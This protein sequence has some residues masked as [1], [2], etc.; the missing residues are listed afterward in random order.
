M[1]EL[2]ASIIGFYARTLGGA[3]YPDF[4]LAALDDN[5]PGGHSPAFF[6]VLHQPLPTTPYNWSGDP[7]S[8][9]HVY[10]HFFLAHEVAHQ[11]WGQAIGWK[12]YHEQWLS[13]GLAQYFAVLYAVEDRGPDVLSSLLGRMRDSAMGV[14]DQGPI[15][16]GYRLG[17]LKNDGRVFRAVVYNKSAVVMHMLRRLIGDEAFFAGLRDFYATWL[18]KKAGTGDIK[19]S[20]A[21]HTA[22][23]LD[24]FFDRW[25]Q[26]ASV[27][28]VRVDAKIGDDRRT[29]TLRVDQ[30]DDVFDLPL[31][32]LVRFE[33]GRTELIDLKVTEEH[34]EHHLSFDQP[35]RR[36]DA[37][38]ELSLVKIE[39]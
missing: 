28:R 37:R 2:V 18:F 32:V 7:V 35:V 13:E 25:I 14:T 24:R 16:L 21:R 6:A 17:H 9:E 27:P 26:G 22:M 15:F 11:W 36:I 23:P 19:A 29:A 1:P 10:P 39:R 30:L 34:S 31:S 33:D 5:L 3:P 4:T 38:D 12:N 8:F 20:F